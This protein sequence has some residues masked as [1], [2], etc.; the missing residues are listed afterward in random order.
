MNQFAQYAHQQ[1]QQGNPTLSHLPILLQFNTITAF[2]HIAKLL[3]ATDDYHTEDA[4][5]PFYKH[6]PLLGRHTIEQQNNWPKNLH[7]TNAQFTIDHHPWI[8]AFPCPQLRDNILVAVE[9]LAVCDELD[10]CHDICQY[11]VDRVLKTGLIVWGDAE[12]MY[13]WEFGIDFLKKWGY[14]LY[15][16]TELLVATNYW[17]ARRGEP[18][19]SWA[20]FTDAIVAT[21]PKGLLE[22]S[23]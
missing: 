16:C 17:R 21:L 13:N 14:L 9:Q 19:I 20:E 11:D 7:P 6:G 4:I 2:E 8:D 10:L 22:R 1:Y 5:S 12:N 3:G 23:E 18:K 15:G